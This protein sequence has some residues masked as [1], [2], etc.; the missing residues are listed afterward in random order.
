MGTEVWRNYILSVRTYAM[1]LKEQNVTNVKCALIHFHDIR[2][3]TMNVGHALGPG[4]ALFV[5]NKPANIGRMILLHV[6]TLH[7]LLSDE[8]SSRLIQAD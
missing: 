5:N 6:T 8:H 7:L 2:K 4:A 3:E 1:Q